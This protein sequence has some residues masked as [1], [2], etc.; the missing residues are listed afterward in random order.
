[1]GDCVRA[2]P[3]QNLDEKLT[4]MDKNCQEVCVIIG[5]LYSL[6]TLLMQLLPTQL[7]NLTIVFSIQSTTLYH[8]QLFVKRSLYTFNTN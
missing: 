5:A 3:L 7:Q 4:Q 1:M 6:R 2:I 8:V